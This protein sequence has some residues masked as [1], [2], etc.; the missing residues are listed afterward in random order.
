MARSIGD[1]FKDHSDSSL[2]DRLDDEVVERQ[3]PWDH[4]VSG[5]LTSRADRKATGFGTRRRRGLERSAKSPSTVSAVREGTTATK[6][7][8]P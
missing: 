6:N 1:W 7:G 8:K 3:E 4:A 2:G 5:M